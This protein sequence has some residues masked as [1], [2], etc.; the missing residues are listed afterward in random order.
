M[1]CLPQALNEVTRETDFLLLRLL[2]K[3]GEGKVPEDWEL[4]HVAPTLDK[5]QAI[6]TTPSPS[7]PHMVLMRLAQTFESTQQ[8]LR[9]KEI[10]STVKLA[11][12][13]TALV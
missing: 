1:N 9:G 6:R 3:L 4:A 8:I 13:A 7:W 11:S 12:K 10:D 5:D 2:H